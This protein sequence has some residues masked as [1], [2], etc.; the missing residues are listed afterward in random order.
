LKTILYTLSDCIVKFS[1]DN[2]NVYEPGQQGTDCQRRPR[3]ERVKFARLPLTSGVWESQCTAN[4]SR[5]IILSAVL[6]VS[7]L[8]LHNCNKIKFYCRCA[9][10]CNN[11]ACNTRSFSCIAVV[12]ML[13]SSLKT[14]ITIIVFLFCCIVTHIVTKSQ[15]ALR[16]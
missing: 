5:L 7:M 2:D 14:S 1:P 15:T 6:T 4:T 11:T 12:S 9:D 3:H 10:L 13:P 16:R 8:L